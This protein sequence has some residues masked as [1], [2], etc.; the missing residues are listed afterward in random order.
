MSHYK[1]SNNHKK[2]LKVVLCQI[3]NNFVPTIQIGTMAK[4]IRA[5]NDDKNKEVEQFGNK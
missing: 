2:H 4:A 5:S 3:T 1:S